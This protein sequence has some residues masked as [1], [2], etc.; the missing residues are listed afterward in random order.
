MVSWFAGVRKQKECV[1]GC[2]RVKTLYTVGWDGRWAEI[3]R[4]M[5]VRYR[6]MS[7]GWETIGMCSRCLTQRKKKLLCHTTPR[8]FGDSLSLYPFLAACSR[9][10]PSPLSPPRTPTRCS[11]ESGGHVNG[12]STGT[13]RGHPI[14]A[15][16]PQR[17]DAGPP[18]PPF[19]VR[20]PT[21]AAGWALPAAAGPPVLS[22]AGPQPPVG[23][24]G[25]DRGELGAGISTVVRR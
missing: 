10:L 12:T 6:G 7:V 22:I 13:G 1:V 24:T 19:P 20:T 17:P 25:R 21:D 3:Y 15:S 2:V 18:P 16:P 9:S 23:P 14:I 11:P 4:R 5:H 8:Y